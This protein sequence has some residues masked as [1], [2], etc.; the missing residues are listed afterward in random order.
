[1]KSRVFPLF[2]LLLALAFPL[3]AWAADDI[4]ELVYEYAETG[5]KADAKAFRA[6]FVDKPDI[7]VGRKGPMAPEAFFRA[8]KKRNDSFS[9]SGSRRI[10]ITT[11]STKVVEGANVANASYIT[12][13][14][15]E[16][17]PQLVDIGDL[18]FEGVKRADGWKIK[19][20]RI[21]SDTP[22]A[23]LLRLQSEGAIP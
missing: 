1:M 18:R 12:T 13:A 4:T 11:L 17:S 5:S 6:L 21:R 2:A 15:I 20:L 22:L 10:H 19:A 9:P 23:D 16:K 8:W 3:G 14:V 7:Q